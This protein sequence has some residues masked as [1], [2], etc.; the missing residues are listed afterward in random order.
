MSQADQSRRGLPDPG[1]PTVATVSDLL[2]IARTVAGHLSDAHSASV[3]LKA[4]EQAFALDPSDRTGE[5]SALLG[6]TYFIQQ[7][8]GDAVR[9]L[10]A[11]VAKRPDDVN[12]AHVFERAVRNCETRIELPMS[13]IEFTDAVKMTRPPALYLRAPE[14]KAPLPDALRRRWRSGRIV[15]GL[16]TIG[17]AAAGLLLDVLLTI[18]R[19]AGLNDDTRPAWIRRPRVFGQLTLAA[20]RDWL[21][22]HVIQDPY[23]PGE[24]TAQQPPGQRRPAWTRSMPTATGAWRTDDPM[25]GAALAR[26]AQQGAQPIERFQSRLEDPRLPNPREVARTFLHLRPG[27]DQTLAPFLNKLYIA[28]IQFQSHDWFSHGENVAGGSMYKIPL[29][30]DDPIRREHGLEVLEIKRTQPDPHPSRGRLT[31]PN[32]VTHWWDASQLYGST[33]QTEDRL[34]TGADGRLLDEGKLHLPENLLPISPATAVED[35]GFTRNWWLGL[36]LFHTLFARHHNRICDE[37]TRAYP[38]HPWTSDQLFKTARLIN[39]AVMAK[40]HTVEWTPAV[41]PNNK[42]APGLCVNWWGLSE[43]RLRPFRKRR[44]QR[45]LKLRHPVLGGLV[46]G[47]RDNHGVRHQFSEEFVSAYRLHEGLTEKIGIRYVEDTSARTYVA[48]D[49]T[50]GHAAHRLVHA[51]G[52]GNL[53]NSFGFEKGGALINN[54]LPKWMTDMSIDGHAVVDIGTIDILRDRERG[55]PGYNELRALQGLPR[56]K[57]YDDLAVDSVTKADLERL[58]GPAPEGLDIL[59]LQV[60][61]LCDRKRPEGFGFDDLRFAF[62]IKAASSR[63]EQD[64]MFCENMNAAVYTE[65]GLNHIDAMDLREVL[66]LECPELR[67]SPLARKDAR[68]RYTLGNSFE[69]WGTTAE[70]HPDEHPLTAKRIERG[71]VPRWTKVQR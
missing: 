44:I 13:V 57:S 59:D 28:W 62:F 36:S 56:L 15:V 31:Y 34:R 45:T 6:E 37:L 52:L 35:T 9:H 68:G 30:P 17:G 27:T 10:E 33:Q 55:M 64:P 14:I 29:A 1:G 61:M 8:Y 26:Y 3:A 46:G 41:L 65:W 22:G 32:E 4:L 21:N 19:R 42:V 43:T 53:F 49:A 50:R 54:N 2:G 7:R 66:L 18:T 16:Q 58:Y 38:T 67:A 20:Y 71:R 5:I 51:H 69:P 48:T 11:A 39:A 40:I 24:L 23:Q 25:E 12:L 60:G 47:R 70:T 63:L